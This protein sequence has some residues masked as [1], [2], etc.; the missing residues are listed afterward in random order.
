[1]SEDAALE[2]AIEERITSALEV[3]AGYSPFL[4]RFMH[5]PVEELEGRQQSDAEAD[6]I[7]KRVRCHCL[8]LYMEKFLT[9]ADLKDY[10]VTHRVGCPLWVDPDPAFS[11]PSYTRRQQIRDEDAE[12]P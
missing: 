6:R 4:N 10:P 8:P 12:R 1:M 2:R 11:Q 9:P 3:R 5:T 7:R